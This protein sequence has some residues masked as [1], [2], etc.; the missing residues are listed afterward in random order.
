MVIVTLALSLRVMLKTTDYW[1][2]FPL[3]THIAILTSTKVKDYLNNV[4][5]F[6]KHEVKKSVNIK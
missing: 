2:T 6:I 1:G 4:I 3:H 5:L